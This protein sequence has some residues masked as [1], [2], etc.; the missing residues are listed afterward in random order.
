V[1]GYL[2]LY[3]FARLIKNRPTQRRSLMMLRRDRVLNTSQPI[4][5]ENSR[6]AL[7]PVSGGFAKLVKIK[8]YADPPHQQTP[9]PELSLRWGT[10]CPFKLPR[11][12]LIHWKS[13]KASLAAFGVALLRASTPKSIHP[14]K[15]N[16]PAQYISSANVYY[17]PRD[18]DPR[19]RYFAPKRHTHIG[20]R[21]SAI[22][23]C[24]SQL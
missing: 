5:R 7:L 18:L 10:A 14:K 13:Q 17:T 16:A 20:S 12:S 1:S 8:V 19:G 22:S 24:S 2:T 9:T 15:I 11:H 23:P 6:L 21:T 3:E 4:T